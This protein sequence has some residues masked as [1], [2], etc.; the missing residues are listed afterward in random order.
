M[1]VRV[2]REATAIGCSVF[3][4]GGKSAGSGWRAWMGD[5]VTRC[6][7]RRLRAEAGKL[8]NVQ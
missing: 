1:R 4:E 3:V 2:P 6:G 7:L 5:E 8:R